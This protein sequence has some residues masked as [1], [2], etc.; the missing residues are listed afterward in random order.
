MP[1]AAGL[2][3]SE[4]GGGARAAGHPP[5]VLIHGAGGNRL[6]WPPALRRLEGVR[7]CA[8]DLPG[9]GQSGGPGRQTIAGY[10][11][12]LVEWMGAINPG[13]AV[14]A[15]HSMGGAVALEMALRYPERTAGLVLIGSGARLRIHPTMLGLAEQPQT[16]RQAVDLIVEWSFSAGAPARLVAL[17]R[18][19]MAAA[20]AG[21]LYTDLVA[22]DHFDVLNSLGDVQVPAL[23]LYGSEDRLTPEKFQQALAEGMPAASAERIAGAGHMVMLEQPEAVRAALWRFLESRLGFPMGAGGQAA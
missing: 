19:R 16:H 1:T 7:V 17:A 6:F 4:H 11:A 5:L 14:L 8:V 13:P 22:C 20:S 9:H 12:A 21:V 23:V 18:Q 2:T 15:G 3:Y 10:A